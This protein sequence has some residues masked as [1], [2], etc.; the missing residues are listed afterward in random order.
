MRTPRL[1]PDKLGNALKLTRQ[2][3]QMNQS[4]GQGNIDIHRFD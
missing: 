1:E 4:S 2:Q 3:Q